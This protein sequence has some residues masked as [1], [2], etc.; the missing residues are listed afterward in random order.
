MCVCRMGGL[1]V[2]QTTRPNDGG[3]E[4]GGSFNRYYSS[5]G[6]WSALDFSDCV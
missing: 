3:L 5:V 4:G 6:G 1:V 2:A